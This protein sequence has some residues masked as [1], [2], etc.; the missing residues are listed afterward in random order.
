LE[1]ESTSQ[2]NLPLKNLLNTV[3]KVMESN[4]QM[5][6]SN[7]KDEGMSEQMSQ[8]LRR[9]IEVNQPQ[10]IQDFVVYN[11]RAIDLYDKDGYTLLCRAV[12]YGRSDIVE[13]LLK[14]GADPSK[15]CRESEDTPLHIAV[16]F[17]FKKVQDLLLDHNANETKVN[18]KGLLPWQGIV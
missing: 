12:H 8:K 18:K 5:S 2:Q 3:N 9:A 10:V 15:P 4:N 11:G 6:Q 16:N 7:S 1:A 13:L 14:A 17:N